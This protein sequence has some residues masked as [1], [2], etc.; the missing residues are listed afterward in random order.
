MNE[1][2]PLLHR[3]DDLGAGDYPVDVSINVGLPED[4]KTLQALLK[5][6]LGLEF[7][8]QAGSMFYNAAFHGNL[9]VRKDVYGRECPIA[10]SSDYISAA[11]V[12]RFS[13]FGRLFTIFGC[14]DS[15]LAAYPV[16]KIV[17]LATGVGLTTSLLK[18]LKLTTTA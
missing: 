7:E 14:S 11:I 3:F 13:N 10:D 1:F 17:E 15:I 6:T 18:S 12:L 9:F 16:E 2:M 5:K 8:L 4:V